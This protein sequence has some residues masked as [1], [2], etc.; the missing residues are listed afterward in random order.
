MLKY[1]VCIF[2]YLRPIVF[3]IFIIHLFI[4][5]VNILILLEKIYYITYNKLINITYI[6]QIIF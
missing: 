6:F 3:H 4:F 2:V 1:I 5:I